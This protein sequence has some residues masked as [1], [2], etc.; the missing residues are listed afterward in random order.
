[1]PLTPVATGVAPRATVMTP[2][3]GW[4]RGGKR[5]YPFPTFMSS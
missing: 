4:Q 3:Y 5:S 1:M 2:R